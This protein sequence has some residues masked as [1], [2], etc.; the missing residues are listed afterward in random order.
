[1]SISLLRRTI[2]SVLALL[3]LGILQLPASAGTMKPGH[4]K[5]AAQT[6]WY[7]DWLAVFDL[8]DNKIDDAAEREARTLVADGKPT[9]TVPVLVTFTGSLPNRDVLAAALGAADPFYYQTQPVA[10][11]NVPAQNLGRL[12]SFPGIAA[13]ELNM[14]LR[15]FLSVSAPATQANR[16]TGANTF[17][18][19]LTAEDLGYTGEGMVVAV[20]DTGVQ[21]I[22]EAFEGKWLAGTDVTAH[23]PVG[24]VPCVTDPPDDVGHGTHVASTA[25]G[26]MPS[27]NLYGTAKDAKL[28]EIRI[29]A[30][31][32]T[33]ETAFAS[34]GSSNRGF[35]FVKLYNDRLAAGTPLCGPSDD[36]I[37]VATLSFG[38]GGRGGPNAGT[39]EPFID[40][41]VRS[42]VT[43]TIAAGNCGPQNSATCTF[44]DS[45]NGIS[46][47]GNAAG[48]ITVA[49][50]NDGDTV[51]RGD[52]AISTS[53]SRG[54]NSAGANDAAAGGATSATNLK[55][56]YRK[57]DVAAPGTNIVAAGFATG[58]PATMSG[59]SMATPHVAGIAALILQA[60]EEAKAQT[61]GVNLMAST[62]TGYVSD[63]YVS[64]IHPVRDALTH[65]ADYKANGIPSEAQKWTGPNSEGLMWNNTWGYGHVTAFGAICWA[66]SHVLAPGGATPPAAVAEGCARTEPDPGS[67]GTSGGPGR[68]YFHS[69]NAPVNNAD[70]V[71][72]GG[73]FYSPTAPA[74]D[75]DQPAVAVDT[76][77][78]GNNG[79]TFYDATWNGTLSRKITEFTIDFFHKGPAE[80]A[81]ATKNTYEVGI[82]NNG[83]RI[84][85]GSFS[86][87]APAPD[88]VGRATHTFTGLDITPA[89][90]IQ[91]DVKPAQT[92]TGP[93][94][95]DSAAYPSGFSYLS[96]GVIVSDADGDGVADA[97][98]N[99]PNVANPGQQ[100][101]DADGQGDACEPVVADAD[102]DGVADADDNC[103]NVANPGQEDA[104]SDGT[105]DACDSSEPGEI[106][107]QGSGRIE[108]SNPLSTNVIGVTEAEYL[109]WCDGLEP[110]SQ[111]VDGYWYFLDQAVTG[112]ATA[113]LVGSE[114]LIGHDLDMYFYSDD[115]TRLGAENTDAADETATVPAG[116][117][118]ILAT[119]FVGVDTL[120]TLTVRSGGGGTGPTDTDGDGVADGADNCPNAANPGQLD[121]DGDGQG[122][123]CDDTP[124]GGGGGGG[125]GC[126]G[127]PDHVY[128][129]GIAYDSEGRDDFKA[130]VRNFETFRETLRGTYCIPDSQ[131]TIFAMDGTM[132][133]SV[134]GRSYAEGSEANLKAEIRRMG[135]EAN[136]YPD[137]QFFFFLSSHGNVWSGALPGSACPQ[138]RVLGSFSALK[139][140]NGEDGQFDDCELGDE[141]NESFEPDTRMFVAVDCS[142]CGG[143]SD[144]VTA[145]SGTIPDGSI[146][147]SAGV[148]GPGRVVVT[149]CAQTTECFGSTPAS[150]GAVLYHHMR[151]V[152]EGGIPA[153]DGW[154][155]PGFPDVQ[156]FDVPVNDQGFNTP[157]GRCT[158]SEVFFGAVNSAYQS[159]DP[160]AIQEQFRIKYGLDSLA[161]DI[162]FISPDNGPVAAATTVAFTDTSALSGQFTDDATF[163]ATLLDD[164]GAPIDGATLDFTL[165][166]EEGS[167]EWSATTGAD[168]VATSTKSLN[169]KPGA[170]NLTVAYS[171]QSDVFEPS[172]TQTGFVIDKEDTAATLQLN[173]QGSPRRLTATIADADAQSGFDGVEVE[174]FAGDVSLGTARTDE[175][176]HASFDATNPYD[177][178]RYVYTA[179]FAGNGFLNGSDSSPSDPTPALTAVTYTGDRTGFHT[180]EATLKAQL[181][182]QDGVPVAGAHLVFE[183]TGSG[184]SRVWEA[185]TANDG[186]AA[187]TIRLNDPAGTYEVAVTYE[188]LFDTYEGSSAVAPL[189]VS[190]ERTA[191]AL[192]VTGKGTKRQMRAVLTQDDGPALG[193]RVIV[194]YVNGAEIARGTTNANGV[195]DVPAPNGYR[196]DHFT[197]EA[198]FA[199]EP[200]FAASSATDQT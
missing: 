110:F 31:G 60:G 106:I 66:W 148:V 18:N 121:T 116:T 160:I 183:V 80:A 195:V 96:D 125:G 109:L 113:T 136:Q 169:S 91:I 55:D 108:G 180:D 118:Y 130:D 13:V 78:S 53:S 32:S 56:R 103:P 133:D 94:L 122:D 2:A 67:G 76:P 168:G 23:V 5:P 79:S 89:G 52:D 19:G 3:L 126:A 92:S 189:V 166:G 159:G 51:T 69:L 154:T 8:N 111:G 135:A 97:D 181:V 131:A 101:S 129:L 68:Y 62:G 50:S 77:L 37:D 162:V 28:V 54:P 95:F 190:A 34:V 149:G 182:D 156:G 100:D 48:A 128:F 45:D 85:L 185:F 152:L 57:P 137:S 146:P 164:A 165:T 200:N 175:L 1:M 71:F 14:K 124:N 151:E 12:A 114:S 153:C 75:D 61:G 24:T 25:V 102:S 119:A 38:S 44:G 59:T 167:S 64:G 134:S 150:D 90:P 73:A 170:Y 30:G 26:S 127:T 188:G 10:E 27:Q 82:W 115:C 141:L 86:V 47:P 145:V 15:P 143:F 139:E 7:V 142:F 20:L 112:P 117:K 123:A 107:F 70:K 140:G 22:Q 197:F 29:G 11:L 193:S 179:R 105:G 17:Y 104:D 174:F 198:R 49:N 173:R 98:D 6:P 132:K 144:S 99:C 40:A 74:E 194:F 184:T 43:V 42:G 93:I 191:M 83:V 39:A 72:V 46:S 65:A 155:A 35:E 58:Q 81:S 33:L 186:V 88:A 177:R 172:S 163:A 157:D 161:D 192:D 196:G 9:A 171:G 187:Q 21:N 16:G 178:G 87:P 138:T 4:Q 36:H 84:S 41:L 158:G 147:T 63:N 120:A 199:G 176:G